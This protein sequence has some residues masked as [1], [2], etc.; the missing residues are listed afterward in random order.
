MRR[1]AY[2]LLWLALV[3]NPEPP[4][5]FQKQILTERYLADGISSGDFNRDGKQDIVSGPF[6]YEG[7]DYDARIT[8]QAN[9]RPHRIGQTEPVRLLYPYYH[10]TLQKVAL[11]LVGRKITA[12]LQEQFSPR[13][14]VARNDAA[15]RSLEELPREIKVLA[16][17]LD[18]LMATYPS[19]QG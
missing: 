1:P 7:P 10:G 2:L 11:D 18:A 9:G 8:R 6:W 12:A 15:V 5:T 14:I 3:Q 4:V 13:A 17:S 19:W 16:G